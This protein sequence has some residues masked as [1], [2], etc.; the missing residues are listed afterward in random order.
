MGTTR[1]LSA[2]ALVTTLSLTGL[3]LPAH[4]ANDASPPLTL[5]G[6]ALI[7]LLHGRDPGNAWPLAAVLQQADGQISGV[8]V[9]EEGQHLRTNESS[10]IGRVAKGRGD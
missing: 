6:R 10:S 9:D 5:N 2:F 4:A 1:R 3:P 8:L 7:Q